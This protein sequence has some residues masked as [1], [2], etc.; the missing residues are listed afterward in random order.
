MRRTALV[1]CLCALLA[2]CQQANYN[3][4][5]TIH[6]VDGRVAKVV[7]ELPR[8]ANRDRSIFEVENR[9][10]MD[11]LIS[12][13]ESLVLDLKAAR[14]KMPVQEPKPGNTQQK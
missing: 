6:Q 8:P 13:L 5:C 14:D 4:S 2:G 11:K 12:G 1:L 3:G 9:E 10:Q 7:V